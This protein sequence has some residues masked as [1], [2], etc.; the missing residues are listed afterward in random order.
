MH[1]KPRSAGSLLTRG[2]MQSQPM[3]T[4]RHKLR[5]IPRLRSHL[6]NIATIIA[7]YVGIRTGQECAKAQN[8]E[9]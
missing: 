9:I 5:T 1:D 4:I 2:M 3:D 7:Q 8:T 6:S